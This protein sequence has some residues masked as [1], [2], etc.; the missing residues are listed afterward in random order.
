M[1]VDFEKPIERTMTAGE[2][3]EYIVDV[4][5]GSF[6]HA[7]VEQHGI[8]FAVS[9]F[10]PSGTPLTEID[11]LTGTESAESVSLV[12]KTAGTYRFVVHLSADADPASGRYVVRTAAP[13]PATPRD[14]RR[15]AGEYASYEALGLWL[16]ETD[17]GRRAALAKYIPAA[18][19]FREAAE[20][21][22]EAE[23]LSTIGAIYVELNEMAQALEAFTKAIALRRSTGDAEG[24]AVDLG[25]VA[26][27]RYRLGQLAEAKAVNTRVLEL[28]EKMG[29]KE[30]E[31]RTLVRL[32]VDS[33]GLGNKADALRLLTRALPL[34]REHAEPVEEA[35]ALTEIG[36]IHIALADRALARENFTNALSAWKRS[37]TAAGQV[38]GVSRATRYLGYAHALDGDHDAAMSNYAQALDLSR[39]VDD[40][41]GVSETLN[42]VGL[43]YEQL[44]DGAEAISQYVAAFAE[45]ERV[46]DRA[47][48]ARIL[49]NMGFAYATLERGRPEDDRAGARYLGQSIG[50]WRA[51]GDKYN[52]TAGLLNLGRL[53]VRTGE[54][55]AAMPILRQAL[56]RTRAAGNR[57]DEG[58]ALKLLGDA[59]A[60]RRTW[61][62]ALSSYER[63]LPLMRDYGVANADAAVMLGMARAER[64]RGRLE[65]ARSRIESALEIV[66]AS[67]TRL[68]S[69]ELRSSFL[70]EIG[71]Y[72][73]VYIDIL[74]R[75]HRRDPS[76]G[77]DGEALQACERGR[78]RTL[79][80]L[81][82]ETKADIGKSLNPDTAARLAALRDDIDAK[83]L[84]EIRARASG[85][86]DSASTLR[87]Q[88][89]ELS[90]TYQTALESATGADA[91]Y[92]E[93]TRPSAL[94]AAEIQS[95]VLDADTTLVEYALGE[96]RSYAWVVTPTSIRSFTLPSRAIIEAAAREVHELATSP[97]G[98][99]PKRGLGLPTGAPDPTAAV[100]ERAIR[101]FT[102]AGLRLNRFVLDPLAKELGG[103]RLLVVA[104]GALHFVPF[105]ALPAPGSTAA[106]YTPLIAGREVVAA[107]S[108]STVVAIRRE[109]AARSDA[110]KTL[111][112]VADPVFD[113]ADE[114]I[115]QPEGAPSPALVTD[116]TRG[117]VHASVNA[118][119]KDVAV[120]DPGNRIAIPRLP[121]TR[122][123]AEAIAKLVPADA[124]L[125]ALDFAASRSAALAPN[126]GEYRYVHFATHGFANAARP[127]LSGLVLSLY[128]E[129]GEVQPGFLRLGDVFGM[130]LGAD[131]VVLS[132]CE[133]GLGRAMRGE[134]LIGLTRGFM[135]AGAP[136]VV[137]SLWSV[138]DLATAELMTGLYEGVLTKGMSPSAALRAAQ[139]E[140]YKQG[141]TRAPFY[142]AA[143][144]LQGDWR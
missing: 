45:A 54:V 32:G 75:M 53:R 73:E 29:D 122:R 14:E 64:G 72:Y 113:A 111:A 10:D 22:A 47:G 42:L 13:R 126:L 137:V 67:R 130:R 33:A 87:R 88:I 30:L 7:D 82:A 99:G 16:E 140:L 106:R 2:S 107:P 124:S 12:A 108:A 102:L 90:R 6:F 58:V 43:T 112:V 37:A 143:F 97:T 65:A 109:R 27:V 35:R 96:D 9:L 127:E 66:E 120:A 91:R 128:D 101:A 144:V 17:E 59:Y 49:N 18:G 69:Q 121:G 129:K 133:T 141:R 19:A 5:A 74:M 11:S 142:W 71:V 136:R 23:T 123:E 34:V 1:R 114:R 110:P 48:Q 50:L 24:E 56:R 46:G 25:N 20:P 57:G 132:A 62:A 21:R 28:A 4:P 105:A 80:E 125:V 31:G 26:A 119:A 76:K 39:S 81:L 85:D 94:S 77:Y 68:V 38:A 95:Q 70:S 41:A 98:P 103:K 84:A 52:V 100:R 134:G 63:A 40:R 78:A 61:S 138:P 116:V 118:A 83:S 8:D 131:L 79:V 139:L 86:T 117:F 36:L 3:H 115:R 15:V 60:K 51:L 55:G 93:I 44:G 104:D 135:Y 92:A 89:G